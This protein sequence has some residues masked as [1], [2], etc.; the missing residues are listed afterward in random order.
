[1]ETVPGPK[2]AVL[3]HFGSKFISGPP[4]GGATFCPLAVW[5]P[6]DPPSLLLGGEGVWGGA[7]RAARVGPPYRPSISVPLHSQF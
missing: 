4:L 7:W 2:T 6:R 1:M 5:G 3:D